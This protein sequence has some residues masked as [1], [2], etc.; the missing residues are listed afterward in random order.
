MPVSPCSIAWVLVYAFWSG[1]SAAPVPIPETASDTASTSTP[2]ANPD[3]TPNPSPYGFNTDGNSS[4]VTTIAIICAVGGIAILAA[5]WIFYKRTRPQSQL[6]TI[7]IGPNS[8]PTMVF[9]PNASGEM[10]PPVTAI[11]SLRYNAPPMCEPIKPCVDVITPPPPAY[12]VATG[13]R[14]GLRDSTSSS[15]LMASRPGK[16]R[17][18]SRWKD[19]L[20]SPGRE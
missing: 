14:P 7:V 13:G 20:S 9:A 17:S 15:V 6:P 8:S 3:S 1:V 12:D 16:E 10:M 2:T 5:G 18:D 11:P 19:L 4:P